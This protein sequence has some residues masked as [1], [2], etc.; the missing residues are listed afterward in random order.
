MKSR[1]SLSL[2][3]K[4]PDNSKAVYQEN[5]AVDFDISIAGYT[6]I[7]PHGLMASRLA[8]DARLYTAI[9][10]KLNQR[11][12]VKECDPNLYD[13]TKLRHEYNLLM[14]LP[15][16][17]PAI[18]KPLALESSSRGLMVIFPKQE[19]RTTLRELYL[20]GLPM[21]KSMLIA[22]PVMP[23]DKFLDMASQIASSLVCIHELSIVHRNISP[24]ALSCDNSNRAALHNFTLASR[25]T[26]EVTS[27]NKSIDSK[28]L[29]GNL[30]YM[31]PESTG[32]MNRT[33]DTRSDFYSLGATFYHLLTGLPPFDTNDPVE[34]IHQHIVQ[35]PI[36]P[37]NIVPSIPTPVSDVILK[38]MAKTPEDRYQSAKGLKRDIE[39][40]LTRYRNNDWHNFVAGEVDRNSQFI[41][42]QTLFGR[43]KE[44]SVILSAFEHAK[45]AGGSHL[46]IVKGYS[47]V[48]KTS[49][50]N[51]IQRPVIKAKSYI[52][53]S[54]FDQF[55]RDIPFVSMIQAFR[56]L[57][58][59]LLSEPLSE[60]ENWRKLIQNAVGNNGRVITDVM[61]DV[62]TIIGPQP[63]IPLLGPTESEA[64]FTNVFQ[65]FVSVFGRP[66]RPL[67]LFLDD[68]Q[69]SSKTEL[70]L[71]RKILCSPEKQNLLLIGAFRSNEVLP[72]DL[73]AVILDQ[74]EEDPTVD[75]TT[76]ALGPLDHESVRCIVSTT[77][78]GHVEPIKHTLIE[79]HQ[80]RQPTMHHIHEL[81]TLIYDKTEGNPFFVL[82]LLKSFYTS[83]DISFDYDTNAWHWDIKQL[84]TKE[85]SPNVIDLLI[86]VMSQLPAST[87]NV[88]LL[89]SCIGNRFTSDLLS[90]VNQK[91]L[92]ATVMD[93]WDGLA[94]K[95]VIP[96]DSNYKVPMAFFDENL[97]SIDQHLQMSDNTV[98]D[99]KDEASHHS[100]SMMSSIDESVRSRHILYRLTLNSETTRISKE[101]IVIHFKFLHDR[102]QQ[103]AYSLIPE[104][105]RHKTH[106]QIGRLMLQYADNQAQNE[107]STMSDEE[108]FSRSRQG[109]FQLT[110]Y[111][112]RNIF[113]I[114]NQLNAG[115][116]L[117][118]KLPNNGDEIRRLISLNLRAGLIAQQATAYDA[119]VKYFR[120]A[121]NLLDDSSWETNYN[122]T[123]FVH[124]GLADAL[125]HATAFKEALHWFTTALNQCR[126]AKD[127][128]QIYHGLL[129][130]HMGDGQTSESID[131][132][133]EGLQILGYELPSTSASMES[134]CATISH[135]IESM[136]VGEIRSMANL[137]LT[138][139]VLHLATIRILVSSIP[140]VYFSRPDLL[141][142]IILT[143][144]NAT[145]DNKVVPEVTYIYTLYGL[146]TIGT[147]MSKF[148]TPEELA[149]VIVIAYEW[150]RL[151]VTSLEKYE[152][153]LVKCATLKVYA[154]H[155]QCWNEPLANTYATFEQSI[156]E[157]ISTMNG[158]YVGYGCVEQCTYMFFAGEALEGISDRCARYKVIMER[159]RQEIGNA[160]LRI[161]YQAILNLMNRGNSNPCDLIGHVYT[162]SYHQIVQSNNLILHAFCND[163]FNLILV[164]TFRKKE[165]A[166]NFSRSG[167]SS[168]DGA[169]GL[170][171][172]AMFYVFSSISFL[173]NWSQITEQERQ[174]V[175]DA[176]QRCKG[177]AINAPQFFDHKL[178]LLQALHYEFAENNFLSAVDLYD[179]AIEGAKKHG[180]IQITAL[181][182]ELAAE[183]YMRRGKQ[184]IAND[185]LLESYY[186]YVRWGAE[187]KAKD[188]AMQ[189]P[190]T[191]GKHRREKAIGSG[192]QSE[193]TLG[194]MLPISPATS[195][196]RNKV[197]ESSNPF[198]ALDNSTV[199][200]PTASTSGQSVDMEM[201][202]TLPI[203]EDTSPVSTNNTMSA[204]PPLTTSQSYTFG[205][206]NTITSLDLDTVMQ[207][208]LVLSE[209]IVLDTLLEK[210]MHILL[211][212][213]S[214]ERVVLLL[215]KQKKLYVEASACH[216]DKRQVTLADSL[217]PLED[218]GETLPVSIVYYVVNTKQTVIN[219]TNKPNSLFQTDDYILAK[220]PKSVMCIPITHQGVLIGVLYL[221]NTQIYN[222]F[223]QERR[224][225]LQLLS[226][227]AAISIQKARLYKDLNDANE[228]LTKSHE[229]IKEYSIDLEHKVNERTIE[230]REKNRRLELEIE[231]RKKAEQEMRVAKEQAEQATQMKN[232]FLAN[233]SHEIRT[234][235]NA[236]I[237]M[238]H[239]LQDTEL[240]TQQ[241]DY[242]E[243]I[244]NSSEELLNI[245][246]DILDFTKI[247][248]DKLDLEC[249]PFSLRSCAESVMDVVSAKAASKGI[250]IIFF[251]QDG[252]QVNDWILGDSTRFRQIVINLL[253]NAVKFTDHGQVI[254]TVKL[255]TMEEGLQLQ[256][257]GVAK[258][259]AAGTSS[260]GATS[261]PFPTSPTH[262]LHVSVS[263][264]GIGIPSDRIFRLFK[265]F[266][267]ID[268]STTRIHGGTGLGLSIAERLS[269]TMGGYMWVESKGANQGSTFHFTIQTTPQPSQETPDVE[270]LVKLRQYGLHCLIVD[271]NEATRDVLRKLIVALGVHVH[272]AATFQEA[273]ALLVQFNIRVLLIDARVGAKNAANA[274]IKVADL[275][276]IQLLSRIRKWESQNKRVAAEAIMMTPL[277][278]RLS[279]TAMEG[280]RIGT[281]CNKPVRRSRLITALLD[282]FS[283]MVAETK[284]SI[285]D[286][287]P[288]RLTPTID[289]VKRPSVIP[290]NL[291]ERTGPLKILVAEDNIINQ[292]VIVQLLKRMGFTTDIAN[293]GAE[294]LDMMEATK[295][296]IVFLDLNMPKKD[297]LTVAR[298]ACEKYPP[299]VRPKLVA[300]TANAMRGDKEQCLQAGCKDYIAKPILI[301]ELSRVL[302][303]CSKHSTDEEGTSASERGSK[304]QKLS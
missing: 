299:D 70:N 193:Y 232:L 115:S 247:E 192:D 272:V 68:L 94:A 61:P 250:E 105:D 50:V 22:A 34:L 257:S 268:N 266:S 180:F 290:K 118:K 243:T 54:K 58:R 228:N 154:S 97:E 256:N 211:Q 297:G 83:S 205:E 92:S 28:L 44:R 281:V 271:S 223:T 91:D 74:L 280:R 38:M 196:S 137:A 186:N 29:E 204:P 221:E 71:I 264:T 165:E 259:S 242:T 19:G 255:H 121:I 224:D 150:G 303:S 89:A 199:N 203:Y 78:I 253:S 53:A 4:L 1:P 302:E 114:T 107:E 155:V 99:G 62:E 104:K 130:C 95:L 304:R 208:S 248:T 101:P 81:T 139:D 251:N 127:K 124:F 16:D 56:D 31:S 149:N 64:R 112:D 84:Y 300:M 207:A 275:E 55:G 170:L 142:Y 161:G 77:L 39:I 225:I 235:F 252:D 240:D 65:R 212:T 106:L 173:E 176:I 43:S 226:S 202:N 76:V 166:L 116:D 289:V 9:S 103:A 98:M 188:M 241:M 147:A 87:R 141:P 10:T 295:Y 239:L 5:D 45:E 93:L 136:N 90:I 26:T 191:I 117:L 206:S 217:L 100:P 135:R 48:G 183:F 145:L 296:D 72:G 32:R 13:M 273:T 138:K 18:V 11:V 30:L 86:N 229:Q 7:Q 156:E 51:E 294:A 181:A 244:R 216:S 285:S 194:S 164:T 261:I 85:I 132:V 234:P 279:T 230:L 219:D 63:A 119:S 167:F 160:Y 20:E 277:G 231:N 189:Y 148:T 146:L 282:A 298:E 59:Q 133:L 227:Q 177:W 108:L 151:A 179:A 214:A 293:D 292:K 42:P 287:R 49:L 8:G 163:L 123:Y 168:I 286:G 17:A 41:L 171:H 52:A 175:T 238:T 209:E 213:A 190:T 79:R 6:D 36:P 274:D 269:A 33:I 197:F 2:A 254:L 24:G 80:S 198:E 75:M 27:F 131:C 82:Q 222:G 301:P 25:L 140:P 35:P 233:M 258:A 109:F 143:G 111:L 169:I 185:Y 102:V 66:S 159:F 153:T 245:I 237:G 40:L 263:D 249:H 37:H 158:E 162:E 113:N 262:M 246:N 195:G 200:P 215:E 174:R 21:R 276:G 88:L 23:L 96:L 187:A 236:V 172:T 178:A 15:D 110:S 126:F 60:L 129:K 12:V 210:L 134:Y 218:C 122:T 220:N 73:L 278:V 125:Y 152:R 267:Q 270:A 157:G 288:R 201:D 283:A 46:L 260:T 67:V 57:I 47:G 291:S 182:C 69:W 184:R 128:A 14:S 3:G 144:L 284:Q 265:L 120:H